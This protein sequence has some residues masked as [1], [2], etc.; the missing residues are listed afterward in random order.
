[1]YVN[2][3]LFKYPWEEPFV[4]N[5]LKVIFDQNFHFYKTS[6]NLWSNP[7]RVPD[8]FQ[9]YFHS[10]NE[11]YQKA[12]PSDEEKLRMQSEENQQNTNSLLFNEKINEYNKYQNR[13][14]ER[15][16]LM[17]N[18]KQKLF[19]TD[20]GNIAQE[21]KSANPEISSHLSIKRFIPYKDP[22]TLQKKITF[23]VLHK[24]N[25]QFNY[26]DCP[27]KF[28]KALINKFILQRDK[29]TLNYQMHVIIF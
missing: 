26:T 4:K 19:E 3:Q 9:K 7:Y 5:Q 10:V 27:D 24:Q 16:L 8:K 21:I 18:C 20:Q 15:Q 13:K 29:S 6:L 23:S 22:S 14:I 1:M 17:L 25:C 12:N 2:N 28:A 11:K